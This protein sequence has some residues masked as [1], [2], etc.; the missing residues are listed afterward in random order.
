[1]FDITFE[2][3]IKLI[4]HIFMFDITL[5]HFLYISKKLGLSEII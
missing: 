1:M 2:H 5:E 4:F 3:F